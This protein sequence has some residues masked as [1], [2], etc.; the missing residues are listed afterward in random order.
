[1]M[2]QMASKTTKTNDY[3]DRL[4]KV[5]CPR[6]GAKAF[7]A[8]PGYDRESCRCLRCNLKVKVRFKKKKKEKK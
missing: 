5:A 1:M 7:L 8:G 2:G 4:T 3:I 6:C